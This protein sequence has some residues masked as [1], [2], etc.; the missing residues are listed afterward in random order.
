MQ[1]SPIRNTKPKRHVD[2]AIGKIDHVVVGVEKH[3]RTGIFGP[4]DRKFGNQPLDGQ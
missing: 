1:V 2:F 3:G 4:K